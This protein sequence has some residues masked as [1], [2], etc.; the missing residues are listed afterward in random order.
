M[1][2]ASIVM[3]GVGGRGCAAL[4][5]LQP[6]SLPDNI[7]RIAVSTDKRALNSV[8]CDSRI[9]IGE[10]IA[11]GRSS[12][13]NAELAAAA[14]RETEP[15]LRQA[16]NGADVIIML[17]GLG[18][19]NGSGAATGL[20]KLAA[21]MAIPLLVF[22]T[23]PF[24]FEGNR[25][26]QLAQQSLQTLAQY[27][28]AVV[29]LPNDQLQRALGAST[30]LEQAL[31]ASNQFLLVILQQLTAMLAD[32]GLIN[33]DFNDF[34]SVIK[35]PGFALAGA[36]EA[37]KEAELPAALQQLLLN[38]LLQAQQL[39][40]AKSALLHIVADENFS[41]QQ[42]EALG[43]QL[44][45]ELPNVS[46]LLQGLTLLPDQTCKPKLLLLASGISTDCSVK[47]HCV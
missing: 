26:N 28:A 21:D 6:H 36:I 1:S 2:A 30:R 39:S 24:N 3:L 27:G 9:L 46:L 45:V 43:Q 17:T 33:M 32:T 18:G 12:G 34:L 25:R 13:G 15:A 40:Q 11:R 31:D 23:L 5:H 38:P 10:A 4:Q 19:G 22:A 20:A 37:E 29:A 41:L 35:Q 16:L 44:A 14:V 42:F 7:S 47:L 8:L